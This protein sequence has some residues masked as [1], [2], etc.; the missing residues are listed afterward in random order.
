VSKA[1]FTRP[2][3]QLSC[4][5][6][7]RV[8]LQ[9]VSCGLPSGTLPSVS[10]VHNNEHCR[11]VVCL[12]GSGIPLPRSERRHTRQSALYGIATAS[13]DERD[14]T[15]VKQFCVCEPYW[16]PSE[17]SANVFPSIFHTSRRYV[18]SVVALV[19][20]LDSVDLSYTLYQEMYRLAV[21]RLKGRRLY[22][23]PLLEFTKHS[24]TCRW[25]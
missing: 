23:S 2:N 24:S 6:T 15:N 18:R 21:G 22:H 4:I 1:C 5:R 7:C 19:D 17:P 25:R 20:L 8:K 16:R 10:P 11:L 3:L 9:H 12:V 14:T 13:F